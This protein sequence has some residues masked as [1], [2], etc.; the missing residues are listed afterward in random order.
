MDDI[1]DRPIITRCGYRCDLCLAYKENIENEKDR[2]IISNGWFKYFGFRIPPEEISCDGCLT[3]A[4]EKPH[5]IDDDCPVR[6]CVIDKGIDNCSQCEESSCKKFESRVVNKEDFEDIPEE[7][8]HRF[9]RPYE[10]KRRFE[11]NR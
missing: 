9:I 8:Y 11:C 2:K 4:K 1:K 6:E 3:P 10:N 7:D 5:L